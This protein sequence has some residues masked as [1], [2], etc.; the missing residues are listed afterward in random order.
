MNSKGIIMFNIGSKLVV[1]AIVALYSLRKYYS[2]D[3]TFYVENP[4]PPEFDKALEYFGCNIVHN[5]ERPDYKALVRKNS[6]FENP[7]YDY[8]LW[9]D[10]DTVTV[11]K[12][13]KMFDYLDENQVELCIPW[14]AGWKSTGPH[15][16]KRINGFKGI[17][18][19]KYLIEALKEHPAINTGILSFKKSEKWKEFV[20]YWTDLADRGAKQHRF[21]PD[22]V[23]LQILYPSMHEW[24]LKYFIAPSDYNTSVLHGAYGQITKNDPKNPSIIH[25]H[26]SK[27]V[28][29]ASACDVWKKEFK[30][31]CDSN[32]AN[33]ND[34]LKYADKRL[35]KYLRKQ[36]G[37]EQ[38]VTI[39]T[40][41]D[42]NY[43]EILRHTFRNWQKYKGIDKYPVIVF[44]NGMDL[45]DARLDY[46]RLPN[47]KLIPWSKEKDLDGVTEHREEML[48][49]FVIG[50]AKYVETDY[51]L[52]LDADSYATDSRPFV[53]EKMK[54]FA[55]FGHKWGYS[56]PEHIKL[57]DAW[58]KTHWKRKLRLAKPM[59]EEGKIEG[60]RFYHN[61][62]RTIS[63]IQLHRTRFTKFC[64]KL[65]KERRLPAPTQDTFFFFVANKFNPETV[66]IGNFK[67]DYG[68]TQGRGKLG[69]DHIRQCVEAV[70]KANAE[71]V[72]S[73]IVK[74]SS[75]SSEENNND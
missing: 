30:E 73:V 49:A 16:A 20:R 53:D 11:N 61:V 39:V 56:R 75:N 37:N 6:L 52:K 25:F 36:N 69:P 32:I 28:L 2:G 27:H 26:G 42:P 44:V 62:K 43:V 1:R 13:D 14:F 48:S 74:N 40:A 54:Q 41:C 50:A 38:D 72:S 4:Y 35:A 68:F 71:K 17:A 67:R 8:T 12:I 55:F 15:I 65:L 3:I 45:D 63:F 47:V 23:A 9:I 34:F 58:A 24:G 5:E 51:W 70:D 66:G 64:V 21:I 22:E 10:S 7:P 18:E 29:D 60:N 31:M 57:L 33:I 19:E 46:L 59:I